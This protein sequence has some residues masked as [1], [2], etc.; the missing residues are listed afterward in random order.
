MDLSVFKDITPLGGTTSTTRL[1]ELPTTVAVTI[2]VPSEYRNMASYAL[3]RYHEGAV[4]TITTAKNADGEYI[5]LSADGTQII[6]HLKKFSDYALG[7]T[8]ATTTSTTTAK[9]APK[10]GDTTPILPLAGIL[11]CGLGLAVIGK[12]KHISE[13]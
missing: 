10:T 1:I 4:D 9:T 13:K 5:E 7:Y 11:V 12:K 3:Y 6:A 2:T 8:A